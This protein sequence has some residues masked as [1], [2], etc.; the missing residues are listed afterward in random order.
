[1]RRRVLLTSLALGLAKPNLVRAATW[2]DRP[3]RW[4]L[5]SAPGGTA[6]VI[7]RLYAEPLARELGQSIVIENRAGAATNIGTEAAIRSSA[8]GYTIVLGSIVN[9]INGT[10]YKSLPFDFLNDLE[11]LTQIYSIPNVLEVAPNLQLQS[12]QD[13]IAYAKQ[14]PGELNYGSGGS[15][16]TPHLSAI[17]FERAT[18]VEM[19]HVPYRGLPQAQQDLAAGRIQVIFDNLPIAMPLLSDNRARALAVM[20]ES[21]SPLLPAVPTMAEQGLPLTMLVWAGAFA[22]RGTPPAIIERLTAA[23]LKA[24][25]TDLIQTRLRSMGNVPANA[26][27]N[28]FSRFVRGEFTRWADIVQVSGARVD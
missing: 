22:P 25:Q 8:D 24:G 2:P 13:L 7:L 14:H 17:M 21:R 1:M 3:I 28:D 9:A 5:P 6:D 11:P 27:R 20:M 18:G 12:M 23:L 19:T 16:T 4:I 26:D 10:L 15:G